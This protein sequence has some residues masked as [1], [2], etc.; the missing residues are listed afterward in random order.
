MKSQE[1]IERRNGPFLNFNEIYT[2]IAAT[3][4]VVSAF[5]AYNTRITVLEKEVEQFSQTEDKIDQV[6]E[7]IDSIKRELFYL[8]RDIDVIKNS[9]RLEER[10]RIDSYSRLE[11][12]IDKIENQIQH[13]DDKNK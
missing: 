9:Q 8:R 13:I 3:A 11:K 5:F 10:A 2:I 1:K 7:K 12:R 6:I 4:I